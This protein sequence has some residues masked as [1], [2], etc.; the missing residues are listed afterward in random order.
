MRVAG[1]ES[2]FTALWWNPAESG[3]G[4][5]FNNQG[6]TLFATLF[7]YEAAGG[8]P[9]WLVMSSGTRQPDGVTFS[10]PLYRTTG[11]AFN[12]NPVTGVSVATVGTMSVTFS[13]SNAAVL[14]YTVNGTTVRKD[15]QRQVFGSR[16]A[17]CVT[18]TGSRATAAN[19][20]DLW[21]KSDESGWGLNI[22]HQDQTLFA[23][24]FTYDA[25]G[26]ALWL[27]MS[28][29]SRQADGSYQGDL[30]QTTGPAFNAQPFT[31]IGVAR[32]GTMRLAFANGESATLTYSVNGIEVTK[33]ITRQVFASPLPTCTS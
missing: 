15:I 25:S 27:V 14:N 10:G 20:Q 4:I 26:K 31:S 30:F 6:N 8:A 21:W 17:T 23:T 29:G 16:A 22:T 19:Y 32:V 9:M 11:P 12:A 1:A 28:A 3:W 33:A 18:T 2:S 7:T 24:L 13:S 5:N